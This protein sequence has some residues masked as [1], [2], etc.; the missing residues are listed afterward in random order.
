[1][2][3]ETLII[4]FRHSPRPVL[5]HDG[6]G[7]ITFANVAFYQASGWLVGQPVEVSEFPQLQSHLL[8]VVKDSA[9]SRQCV[10]KNIKTAV[11]QSFEAIGYRQPLVGGK[12]VYV[13]HLVAETS[14]QKT[15]ATDVGVQDLTKKS[16]ILTALNSVTE[17]LLKQ[18]PL[19]QLLQSIAEHLIEL[20]GASSTYVHLVKHEKECLELVACAGEY[21]APL[22]QTLAPGIG[23]A[24]QVFKTGEAA[25]VEDY[26]SYKFRLPELVNITQAAALPMSTYGEVQ[27]V[28]GLLYSVM[29]NPLRKVLMYCSSLP[30]LPAWLCIMRSSPTRCRMNW[31][32]QILWSLPQRKSLRVRPYR[33]CVKLL[34][35]V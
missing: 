22:G 14:T 5:V 7:Q 35:R 11:N 23:L 12:D 9:D 1:M 16:L 30:T 27:G 4:P 6:C 25:Y 3:L 21:V 8:C 26:S 17:T 19:D 18:Q 31:H 10:V 34:Q 15:A 20:T 33:V 32:T 13:T 2:D 28:L 24:G 29:K